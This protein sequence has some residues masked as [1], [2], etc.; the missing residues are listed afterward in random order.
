M[1]D[2][3]RMENILDAWTMVERL[4]EGDFKEASPPNMY[5]LD[6]I[7]SKDYYTFINQ[8]KD[9]T[10]KSYKTGGYV[11][12]VGIFDFAKVIKEI[13]KMY[14]LK[15]PEEEIAAGNK[16]TLAIY[17]DNNLNY[18][19]DKAFFTISGYIRKN[20]KIPD[21]KEFEDF[22]RDQKTRLET[23]FYS[24][25]ADEETVKN[26]FNGAISKLLSDFA[27]PTER[28]YVK[29]IGNVDKDETHLHSFFVGDLIKAKTKKT[30]NLTDYLLGYDKEERVDLD[31][32]PTS[33]KFNRDSLEK[34][35]S[36]NRYPL[37]RFPS[38]TQ[39]SLS[40]M[41][42]IAVNLSVGYDDR[43]IR[44]VNGPPGTGKTTLLKDIFAELIVKQAQE[45]VSLT[46]RHIPGTTGLE[47]FK[48]A[49]IGELP[50]CIADNNIIIVSSNNGAVQNIV[51][52]L[53]L[54][55]GIDESLIEELKSAD[56]FRVLSNKKRLS[57]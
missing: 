38:N 19:K 5:P 4:S 54:V 16:F 56:Y 33:K 24:K 29:P 30:K 45:I 9:E 37:G 57:K 25:E 48:T 7:E 22:E 15:S 13:R 14:A 50:E 40:L 53:P 51:N 44:S 8:L 12:Y 36:P 31:S 17:F 28:Y 34:I 23:I 47:Y 2:M 3:K 18:I 52:E 32:K 43:R 35:L 20:G 41:Q 1:E 21:K 39:Y 55:T 42:Q 27:T 11:V 10:E 46:N 26:H 49:S 6:E